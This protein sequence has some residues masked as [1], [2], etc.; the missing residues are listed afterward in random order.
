MDTM[1]ECINLYETE[2]R[3]D[4]HSQKL[5]GA[6]KDKLKK[7]ELLRQLDEQSQLIEA[8]TEKINSQQSE[9]EELKESVEA[10]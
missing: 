2:T 5:H 8:L 3:E 4:T 10:S 7:E 9:L 1:K 6:I